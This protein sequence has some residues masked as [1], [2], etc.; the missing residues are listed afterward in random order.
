MSKPDHDVSLEDG[1]YRFVFEDGRLRCRAELDAIYRESLRDR[2][3]LV[4]LRADLADAQSRIAWLESLGDEPDNGAVCNNCPHTWGLHR[5]DRRCGGRLAP[6]SGSGERG[7][8]PC[9]CAGFGAL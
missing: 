5:H 1:K 7:T 8:Q 9:P 4:I 2:R 3:E 6:E